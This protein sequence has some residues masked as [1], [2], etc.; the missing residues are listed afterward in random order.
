[1]QSSRSALQ[2]RI[3]RQTRCSPF[4]TA[5]PSLDST[6][7]AT[8]HPQ[9]PIGSAKLFA[10]A[11]QEDLKPITPK[12]SLLTALESQDENWTGDERVQDAVLRMLM[13]KHKP[14][15][16]GTIRSADEKL[17]DRN[18]SSGAQNYVR[19]QP[20]LPSGPPASG[21]SWADVP[22]LPAIDGHRPWHATYKVPVH[23]GSIRVGSLRS[24][25]TS[26]R[27]FADQNMD[28]Q[29]R[30]QMAA[31]RR[32]ALAAGRLVRVKEGVLDYRLGNGVRIDGEQSRGYARSNPVSLKGWNSMVEE[33]IERARAAGAFKVISGRGKPLARVSEEFN[34][35]IGREEFLMNRIVQRNGATPPWVDAQME[36]D[37]VLNAFRVALQLSWT[38]RTVRRLGATYNFEDLA[39]VTL[40][41]IA[42]L[43]D[44]EWEAKERSYHETGVEDINRLV[45]KYNGMAPYSVRRGYHDREA[46][47]QLN[48]QVSAAAILQGLHER[49][50]AS[51]ALDGPKSSGS[52]RRATSGHGDTDTLTIGGVLRRWVNRILGR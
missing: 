2:L 10:D 7:N 17:R 47:L 22:L 9:A 51:N 37:S 50:L 24:S 44:K 11:A 8:Q 30:R 43:R 40:E 5:R 21:E 41:D 3:L 20:L 38:R 35:F 33:K 25:R 42:G 23:E 49:T 36:L 39:S 12:S 31:E 4:S 32:K 52:S 16:T 45:R 14:L 13:D 1:M 29:T 46:E 18:S 28:N 26:S 15:R 6:K 19:V 27:P 34:P 48:Y